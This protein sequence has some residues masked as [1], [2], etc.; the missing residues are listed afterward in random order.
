MKNIFLLFLGLAII[1]CKNTEKKEEK[2]VEKK[3]K[4]VLHQ[5][6]GGSILVKKLE[7]FSQD[8]T[9]TGQTKQFTD[10]YYVISHPKGNLM[11][12]A[13]LPE[14]LVV[15]EP[16]HEPSG[17]FAVQRPDSLANQLKTIG[18]KI[19]D[20][21]YFA[22]S[23]SHF[24]HTGHA[25]YMKEATW[26]VQENEYN[27]VASDTLKTKNTAVISLKK[28][29]KLNGDY[30]VFGDGTVVIKYMPGHTVGHQVLY[31][32]LGLEKPI[33]LTG[34]LYH[35]E[36]NRTN[37]G[38]PS[39]NYDVKQTLESMDKF[40]SFAKEKNAEVIIQHSPKSFQRL[41]EILKN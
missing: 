33:L 16:F 29:K 20:F 34:D 17:V 31:I 39:F 13:G 15:P 8:T 24:D 9:Y 6:V 12:D 23:H 30:D 11:W 19:E 40:E 14:N 27:A 18:F 38:V 1:G 28:V 35:F 3:A 4:V 7:V 37:K 26:L 22:M 10:A 41:E 5:L 2:T 25:N 32:D 21:K 36:E